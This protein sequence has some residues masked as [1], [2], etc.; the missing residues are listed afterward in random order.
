M[1]ETAL[2]VL[3]GVLAVGLAM[4]YTVEAFPLIAAGV[5]RSSSRPS[6]PRPA[7]RPG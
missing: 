1:P 7:R 3:L 6:S 5:I 2:R 4:A